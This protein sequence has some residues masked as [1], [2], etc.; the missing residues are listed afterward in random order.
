MST[1]VWLRIARKIFVA[2]LHLFLIVGTFG[3]DDGYPTYIDVDDPIA[4]AGTDQNVITGTLVT[5]DGSRSNPG[6]I[7]SKTGNDTTTGSPLSYTWSFVSLPQG[8][9]A[10][11]SDVNSVKPTFT[12]DVE[13][14]YVVN[15]RFTSTF[16]ADSDSVMI[17]ASTTN[18]AP[19][20]S[21]GPDQN[22]TT[23]SIVTLDGRASSDA[24]NDLL[25]YSWALVSKPATS[26]ATLSDSKVVQPTF[27]ADLD[28]VY[29]LG[30]VVGDGSLTSAEESVTVTADSVN[31]AP[32]ANAGPDQ[33]V[34]I[35][36]TVTLNGSASSDADGDSLA[37]SWNLIATPPGSSAILLNGGNASP[38][39][40]ADLGG[41]YVFSLVVNDGLL[42][43]TV[44]MVAVTATGAR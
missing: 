32:V 40:I 19:V 8:S 14:E 22:I 20:A 2:S 39:F 1:N 12:A 15:L 13:G 34:A 21:A 30:L 25:S 17:T 36:G 3:C 26:S 10:T 44:D 37:Y 4:R 33:N 16:G 31:S 27:I 41:D 7:S 5:L 18:S 9:S 24:N 38:T 43:S 29:V 35:G 6:E 11:L 23:N 42:N 28:G